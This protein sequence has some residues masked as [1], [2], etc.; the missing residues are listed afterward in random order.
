MKP[1]DY[2]A[3]VHTYV[4]IGC[5]SVKSCVEFILA[6]SAGTGA[7]NSVLTTYC[8]GNGWVQHHHAMGMLLGKDLTGQAAYES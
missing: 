5:C 8:I 2:H 7:G 1:E 6:D 3:P 4:C